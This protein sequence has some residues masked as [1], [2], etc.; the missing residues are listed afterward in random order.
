ME[1]E[2]HIK[3]AEDT[4]G[5][6]EV[7]DSLHKAYKELSYDYTA[8]ELI[9]NAV[10]KPKYPILTF[11]GTGSCAP[12]KTR[13]VSAIIIQPADNCYV[14]LDC[15]EGTLGQM[16]RFFG[17][18][19]TD[20]ILQ[21][22]KII[23]VSHQHADHHLGLF[24]ILKEKINVHLRNQGQIK[25]MDKL[26]LMAP[27]Q[28]KQW[29]QYYDTFISR[30]NPIFHFVS[31]AVML[32]DPLALHKAN[33]WFD[34]PLPNIVGVRTCLVRHSVHA[35]AISFEFVVDDYG[36]P[37]KITYSGDTMPCNDLVKLGQDSTI[38]IHEA[39]MED[40][41][42]EDARC[43]FHSTMSQAIDQ[44]IAMN[45][46]YTILTHFSQRYSKMPRIQYKDENGKFLD[47]MLN[48]ALA[49]D[50]MQLQLGDLEYY[51]LIYD[52]IWTLYADD[53][54]QL[55]VKA[56]KRLYALKRPLLLEKNEELPV[57]RK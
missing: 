29:I 48:V 49:F 45:A 2:K 34:E 7:R 47:R 54:E 23:F 20:E 53:I 50:N 39:T 44:G 40:E 43:K 27:I 32:A 16:K 57:K 42:I 52:P 14:L 55:E 5:F 37:V 1:P 6:L 25:E 46:K 3:E 15:G 10:D 19:R 13:N 41:L 11:L 30:I 4:P 17:I 21:N 24:N 18:Q 22:L 56:Q 36:E 8:T 38:L 28:I 26:L 9:G 31:N 12:N 51:H 35:Y 33:V